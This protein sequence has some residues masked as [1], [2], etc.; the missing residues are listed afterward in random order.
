MQLTRRR[1]GIVVGA[2]ALLAAVAVWMLHRAGGH[3]QANEKPSASFAHT[4]APERIDPRKLER[5]SIAGTIRDEAGKPIAGAR[6]CADASTTDLPYELVRD[7]RCTMTDARG[8]Y[9]L[10]D[11]YAAEYSVAAM[12]RQYLPTRFTPD[13][14]DELGLFELRAGE[15]KSGVDIVLVRGGV[16]VT[17]VVSDISGGPI[18]HASVRAIDMERNE[19][20][21]AL[22][23]DDAG[24]F[25]LWVK[26]GYVQ[27]SA[28]ADGYADDREL[29]R[30]PGTV[31]VLLTP[32]SSLAGTVVDAA[33]NPPVAGITVSA[34]GEM[35]ESSDI[36]D[37]EGHFHVTGLA[38]GRYDLSARSPH[39]Y[40]R[41]D[42]SSGVGFGQHVT[43]VVVKLYPAVQIS[44][45]VVEP[46]DK[47]VTCKQSQLSLSQAEPSRWLSATRDAD[48]SLHVDGVLPGTYEVAASCSGFVARDK[49]PPIAITD[50][51]VT[52]LEWDVDSG[53]ELRGRVLTKSGAP[54]DG[55]TIYA[56]S[57]G[58]SMNGP[59]ASHDGTSRKDGSYHLEGLKQGSYKLSVTAEQSTSP[60][61]GWTIEV[62]AATVDQD[63]V[64]DEI[65]TGA[66]KGVV[67]DA[68]GNPVSGASISASFAG[69]P[70]TSAADGSFMLDGV[71][72][73]EQRVTARRGNGVLRKPGTTDDAKHGEPVTVV[74]G[75]T[76]SVRLVVDSRSAAI[77]GTCVDPDGNPITDAYVTAV[78]ESDAAGSQQSSVGETRWSWDNKPTLAGTDGSFEIGELS[79]GAYSV[80][81]ERKGGGEAIAE[82]VAAGTSISL[83]FKPTAQLDGF[84]HRDGS[85]PEEIAIT[86]RDDKTGFSRDEEFFR[87]GGSFTIHDLPAGHFTLSASAGDGKKQITIDLADGEHKTGVDIQLDRLVTVTG[88]IVELGTTTPVAGM[89]MLAELGAS[90]GIPIRTH[91]NDHITDETGR[92]TLDN[93]P[94]GVI[95]LLGMPKDEVS[96]DYG[97]V[98]AV[99]N[100][101]GS[102]TIDVGDIG[103]V[104]RRLKPGELPG[105]LGV[106]WLAQPRDTPPDQRRYEVSWIDPNGAA[107]KTE[108][109]VGDVVITVD[110]VDVTGANHLIGYQLMRAPPATK[111]V[112][113]LAR[114]VAITIVLNAPS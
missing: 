50:H 37:D 97:I 54:V 87:T 95:Q 46:G 90:D 81:A 41:S 108:L 84:V 64:V 107:A 85:A 2:L 79:P 67:V 106:H 43:G 63:L 21:P 74:A 40:G 3:R 8:V 88:R 42:G 60:P 66:I 1:L 15:R 76:A 102:G 22:E 9:Q 23:T 110:G 16:E 45:R 31:E 26:P 72:I 82:H 34:G 113:G 94:L 65:K 101:D 89:D 70:T 105:E 77:K 44:G 114:G 29:A 99:R 96:S 103:V 75:Q 39:G 49:Y 61:A 11:L 17:G 13:P 93:I 35:H 80:R 112:L 111:L 30:A 19:L 27:V 86:L 68:D 18:A 20:W 32:E 24:K 98:R 109:K 14:D 62:R 48:G 33:T 56:Q 7:P 91:G 83:V 52:H 12:A 55:A 53:A 36:T 6:V 69:W 104:K 47:R 71:G 58:G 59:D 5:A 28:V 100:V 51:D 25:S 78:R 57:V 73:G 38:P 92:F 4:F 10:A